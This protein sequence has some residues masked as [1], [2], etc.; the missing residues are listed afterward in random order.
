V[1][2]NIETNKWPSTQRFLHNIDIAA[3]FDLV[4][5]S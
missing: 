1:N 4:K 3:C 5:S 2:L